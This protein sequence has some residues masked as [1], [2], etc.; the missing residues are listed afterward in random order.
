MSAVMAAAGRAT[1]LQ[2]K[3]EE[4]LAGAGKK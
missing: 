1:E 2:K 3:A 4:E